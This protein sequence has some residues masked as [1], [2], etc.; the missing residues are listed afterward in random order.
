[1][2]FK[3]L[4]LFAFILAAAA[5][6]SFADGANKFVLARRVQSV[7][8]YVDPGTPDNAVQEVSV[9]VVDAASSPSNIRLGCSASLIAGACNGIPSFFSCVVQETAV[10]DPAHAGWQIRKVSCADSSPGRCFQFAGH[11]TQNPAYGGFPV[12]VAFN[13]MNSCS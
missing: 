10:A 5:V 13:E 6:P 2:S 12:F 1:M 11:L 7:W 3:K 9:F 4:T 8:F